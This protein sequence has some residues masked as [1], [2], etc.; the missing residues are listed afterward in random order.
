MKKDFLPISQE[1]VPPFILLKMAAKHKSTG[2]FPNAFK[3]VERLKVNT[4]CLL[5]AFSD[6]RKMF[7]VKKI[8]FI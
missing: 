3:R 2:R 6:G 7:Q 5:E 8:D 4:G 1:G